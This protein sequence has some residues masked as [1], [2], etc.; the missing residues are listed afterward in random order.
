MHQRRMLELARTAAAHLAAWIAALEA[1][2]P[3]APS[4]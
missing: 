3:A 1:T 2:V 4:D